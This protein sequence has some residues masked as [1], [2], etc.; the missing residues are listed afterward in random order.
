MILHTVVY[1]SCTSSLGSTRWAQISRLL[2]SPHLRILLGK[3][4]PIHTHP[5][6]VSIGFAEIPSADTSC[7]PHPRRCTQGK[8]AQHHTAACLV[9]LHASPCPCPSPGPS[10]S[11]FPFQFRVHCGFLPV[12]L[13]SIRQFVSCS[14]SHSHRLLLLVSLSDI[15]HTNPLSFFTLP[16]ACL[17]PPSSNPV[18]TYLPTSDRHPLHPHPYSLL[19]LLLLLLL[20]ANSPTAITQS[21]HGFALFRVCQLPLVDSD[22]NIVSVFSVPQV[23]LVKRD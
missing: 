19:L 15:L 12:F 13:L 11:P 16:P 4:R 1:V 2:I 10:S 21:S 9:H 5:P 18:P 8:T 20:S 23:R 3:A 17:T 6:S 7:T 22:P 14:H